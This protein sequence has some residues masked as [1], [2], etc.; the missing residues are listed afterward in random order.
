MVKPCEVADVG[1]LDEQTVDQ[2]GPIVVIEPEKVSKEPSPLVEGFHWVTM[3]L[4]DDQEV[5][6]LWVARA[7]GAC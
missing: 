1:S 5:G 3:D 7:I 6:C 2:E 4:T